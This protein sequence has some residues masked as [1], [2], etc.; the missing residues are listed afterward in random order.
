MSARRL[1][2]ATGNQ[3]KLQQLI[4]VH[5]QIRHQLDIAF[6]IQS[7][8]ECFGQAASYAEIGRTAAEIAAAGAASVADR[9]ACP[10]LTEDT[11]FAVRALDGRPGVSAGQYLKTHGRLGL[12]EEMAGQSDRHA[13]IT[14]A[15]AYARPGE[16]PTVWTRTLFGSVTE[17]ERWQQE[18]PEWIAPS[19][20]NPQ[21]GGYNAILI[22]EGEDRTLAEIPPLEGMRWGYR[23]PLFAAVLI[24]LAATKRVGSGGRLDSAAGRSEFKVA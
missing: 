13:A 8:P 9:V 4:Y 15:V 19:E 14:S 5:E 6:H 7:A 1:L 22:P 10:V 18:L 12:L 17:R 24:Y 2:F 23:E 20:A 11:I 21:G 3:A 16:E